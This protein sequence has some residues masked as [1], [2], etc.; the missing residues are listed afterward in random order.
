MNFREKV[1][2]S[3]GVFNI[4]VLVVALALVVLFSISVVELTHQ[5][6]QLTSD[7]ISL[8]SRVDLV[9]HGFTEADA[10]ILSAVEGNLEM[11]VLFDNFVP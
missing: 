1:L 3:L 5:V 9:E 2:E 10:V 6:E 4:I 11:Q 7:V 8:S